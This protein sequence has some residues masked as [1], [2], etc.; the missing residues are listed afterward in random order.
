ML[1]AL[2]PMM[3]LLKEISKL[4]ENYKTNK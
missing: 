4:I 3:K 1:M 2:K